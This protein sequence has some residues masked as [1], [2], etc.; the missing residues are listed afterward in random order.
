MLGPT[1][2]EA[3][4]F[5]GRAEARL[6]RLRRHAARAAWV[7]Q[8]FVTGDTA[9]LAAEA[10][11]SL[12]AARAELA[13]AAARFDRPD[14]PEATARKLARLKTA[15]ATVAPDHPPL[16]QELADLL[17]GL[18]RAYRAG[19]YCA[20][21]SE[22][23]L[24][25]ATLERTAAELRDTDRLLDLW[26]E[27]RG[28]APTMRPRYERVVEIVNAGA[29][30][31][32]HAD[33][34]ERWRSAYGLPPDAFSAELDRLWNQVRPLYES[35]HCL[36]RGGL[37]EEY[38]TAIAPPR[39]A[40]PAHLLG[41]L[42]DGHW[43]ALYDMVAPRT[44]GRRYDLTRQIERNRVDPL[45]MVGYGERFFDSLGFDPLPATFRDRSLFVQPA[46]RDVVCS[47]SAWNLDGQNDV[48]V[49]MCIEVDGDSFVALH[50]ELARA[51]YQWAYRVQ[52]PLFRAGANDAFLAA[53]GDAIAL[54]VTPEYLVALG[55]LNTPPPAAGDIPFLLRLAVDEIPRLPFALL[56]DRWR[57]QVFEG[58]VKPDRY[59]PAWW[60]LREEYQGVRAPAPL[61]AADFDPGTTRQVAANAPL[62]RDFIAGI[63]RF[64]L[65]G[66]LCAAAGVDG[67][68]HRCSIF[69][70]REA[71]A[72]LLA[73]MEMGASRP[74]PAALEAATGTRQMDASALLEYFAPLSAWLDEQNAGRACGW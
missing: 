40:I 19:A 71:G 11:A 49:K 8:N 57:W 4:D 74:W 18:E 70:S 43:S 17:A 26:D 24:D 67:P 5:A 48:R 32:G 58:A 54:S 33:A 45:E 72:R 41:D 7:R 52:D 20:G 37:G 27:G 2:A 63:L 59:N 35:L 69:G 44:R 31:L 73:M 29:V 3:E 51:H 16:Q 23:C 9:A 62:A 46:D 15:P 6:L 68:L 53:T 12:A 1:A 61:D 66:A 21:S 13:R 30:E 56:V 42:G 60:E 34:G 38:G 47:P 22:D 39:E 25:R 64:Q 14:L 28:L 55:L 36:V 50:R 65:H 10:G